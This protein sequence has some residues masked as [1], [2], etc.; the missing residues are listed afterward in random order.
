MDN[1]GPGL[2][3]LLTMSVTLALYLAVGFGLGWLIDLPFDTFPSFALV[4]LLLGIAG[5]CR[6]FYKQAQRFQ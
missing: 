2:G 1:D 4:G 5:A 3:D 6:Y